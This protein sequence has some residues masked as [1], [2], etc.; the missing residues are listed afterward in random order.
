MGQQ[1]NNGGRQAKLDQKKQRAAGRRGRTGQEAPARKALMDAGSPVRAKGRAGGASGAA[2][3]KVQN[4]SPARAN[5][6]KTG[7]STRRARKQ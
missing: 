4:S 7:R 6:L 2:P 1:A 5:H 3:G